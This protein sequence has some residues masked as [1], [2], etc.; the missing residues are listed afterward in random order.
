M[1]VTTI[2][3]DTAEAM[4]DWQELVLALQRGHTRGRARIGDV[5]LHRGPDTMLTR[6]A[7][8][9]EIGILVKVAN[10]FPPKNDYPGSI[11]GG[12][13]YFD[14]KDG[15]LK[16]VI[17]FHLVTK[18]KTAAD[19]MLAASLLARPDSR[20]ILL[21]GA[22]T[23]ARSLVE[24]YTAI[25]PEARISLWNRTRANAMRLASDM[26]DQADVSVVEDLEN[27]VR[28]A[29][30]VSCSTMATEPVIDGKWLSPGC[31][32]DLIGAFHAGMREADDEV[33]RRGTLFVDARET[34]IRHIGELIAP[35]ANGTIGESDIVADFYDIAAGG[36]RRN[37]PDE[38]TIF[39][40]GGG[41]HLDLMTA[42][43]IMGKWH[44]GNAHV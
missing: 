42:E 28:G 4:L 35:I 38:I 34:T 22:G 2:D 32:L 26:S 16:A 44:D 21:V 10:V 23:V 29:D 43:Y 8:A 30:I 12:L 33:F 31:H 7:W 15:M 13:A 3:F 24:S 19:S 27:A 9:D 39:K 37:D 18:W 20:D 5:F 6:V 17:D 11:N 25:F 40:N 1:M 41:A 36:F 14:G